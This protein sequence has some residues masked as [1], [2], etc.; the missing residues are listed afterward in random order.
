MG[1]QGG[2]KERS[3]PDASDWKESNKECKRYREA[4]LYREDLRYDLSGGV[5]LVILRGI[6]VVS[7]LVIKADKTVSAPTVTG[8]S[9]DKRCFERSKRR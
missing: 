7:V 8:D 6:E 4:E 9:R 3:S 5:E 2:S 1:G